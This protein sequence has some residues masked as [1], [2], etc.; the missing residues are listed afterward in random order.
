MHVWCH[1][2]RFEERTAGIL[3]CSRERPP[4]DAAKPSK[5]RTGPT[6]MLI[7]NTTLT[8]QRLRNPGQSHVLEKCTVCFSRAGTVNCSS[9]LLIVGEANFVFVL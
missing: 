3:A 7:R 4:R 1:S 6:E 5:A 9:R 8:V 2:W